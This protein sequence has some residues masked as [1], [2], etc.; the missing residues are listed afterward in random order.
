MI[1]KSLQLLNKGGNLHLFTS[2]HLN[3]S[4]QK[5]IRLLGNSFQK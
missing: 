2:I 1:T 5:L 4:Y 3:K